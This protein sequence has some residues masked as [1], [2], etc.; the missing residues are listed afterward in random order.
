[1]MPT[2]EGRNFETSYSNADCTLGMGSG[3][4]CNSLPVCRVCQVMSVQDGCVDSPW[5]TPPNSALA[6]VTNSPLGVTSLPA[7]DVMT[8]EDGAASEVLDLSQRPT[9]TAASTSSVDV[10]VAGPDWCDVI[11][12]DN[13]DDDD[14]NEQHTMMSL[15][16]RKPFMKRS[17]AG[18][19]LTFIAYN[20]VVRDYR[21][22]DV[23]SV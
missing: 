8:S 22:T 5:W 3:L 17:C 6:D 11:D 4:T 19:V 12:D 18:S 14:D 21:S 16:T 2:A 13:D 10:T 1:M 15:T 23:T 20:S 9:L 7:D